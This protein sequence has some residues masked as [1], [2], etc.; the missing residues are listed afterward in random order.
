MKLQPE[1]R[2]IDLYVSPKRMTDK[3][4]KEL[5]EIIEQIRRRKKAGKK[6]HPHHK[7]SSVTSPV[8]R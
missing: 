1:P 7:K 8:S 6:T 3:E 4:R 5:G 2:E